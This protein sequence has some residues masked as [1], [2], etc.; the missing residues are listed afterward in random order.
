MIWQGRIRVNL[1]CNSYSTMTDSQRAFLGR[2]MLV[3]AQVALFTGAAG[4]IVFLKFFIISMLPKVTCFYPQ[5]ATR[6]FLIQAGPRRFL[7]RTRHFQGS[8]CRCLTRTSRTWMPR[9]RRFLLPSRSLRF[10]HC[11]VAAHRTHWYR[12]ALLFHHHHLFGLVSSQ[13]LPL[14]FSP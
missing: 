7:G 5:Q 4:E 11:P 6:S 8:E 3:A 12:A 13:L 1:S 10:N 14:V 2:L 9:L